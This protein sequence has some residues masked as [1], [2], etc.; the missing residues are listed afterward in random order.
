MSEIR[1]I[2]IERDPLEGVVARVYGDINTYGALGMIMSESQLHDSLSTSD[3]PILS[4][5]LEQ[6]RAAKT[7]IGI[8]LDI[9][10]PNL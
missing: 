7:E 8:D 4:A 6:L 10:A 1:E 2:L 5:A 3:D 9:I